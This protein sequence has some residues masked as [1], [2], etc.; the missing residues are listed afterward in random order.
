MT[1]AARILQWLASPSQPADAAITA[2]VVPEEAPAAPPAILVTPNDGDVDIVAEVEREALQR[3]TRIGMGE[4][5]AASLLVAEGHATRV[6]LTAFEVW[7]GLMTE[8]ERL[9]AEYDLSIVPTIV[10]PGGRIDIEVSGLF[11]SGE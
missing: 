1:L 4:L 11:H 9:S 2:G 6:V 8:I 5:R 7:P 3:A 10:R